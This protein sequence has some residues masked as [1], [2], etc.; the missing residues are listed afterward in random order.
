M[1]IST[2]SWSLSDWETF[3]NVTN[4]GLAF[5][6]GAIPL[7]LYRSGSKLMDLLYAILLILG[8]SLLFGLYTESYDMFRAAWGL[9]PE[10]EVVRTRLTENLHILVFIV[11]G[12]MLA[13]AANLIT[14]FLSARPPLKRNRDK[15]A[16]P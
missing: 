4:F 1:Q 14:S 8:A 16:P 11:P 5:I 6:I 7:T 9:K 10:E 2:S 15:S 12:V 3:V 13:V